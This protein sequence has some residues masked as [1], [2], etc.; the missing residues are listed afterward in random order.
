MFLLDV[1]YNSAYKKLSRDN[2]PQVG[3]YRANREQI[4]L[5]KWGQIDK[6]YGVCEQKHQHQQVLIDSD[7]VQSKS[8]EL[9]HTVF[10]L[11]QLFIMHFDSYSLQFILPYLLGWHAYAST[12]R[13]DDT[14]RTN[15]ANPRYGGDYEWNRQWQ[16]RHS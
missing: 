6:V 5:L 11:H 8:L 14:A 15:N 2:P 13:A 1:A 4:S 3:F 9:W 7:T 12:I 10:N 16:R